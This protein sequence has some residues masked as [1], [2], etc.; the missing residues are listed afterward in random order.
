MGH[1]PIHS[2]EHTHLR[3]SHN[4]F[5]TRQIHLEI[6]GTPSSQQKSFQ[7]FCRSSAKVGPRQAGKSVQH[8]WN[9]CCFTTM[10]R[11]SWGR[12]SDLRIRCTCIDPLHK[13]W[14]SF[15]QFNM[16]IPFHALADVLCRMKRK[17]RLRR[18][19]KRK[20]KRRRK[21]RKR[22]RKRKLKL[23]LRCW[24]ILHEL[25]RLRWASLM[26]LFYTFIHADKWLLDFYN[27]HTGMDTCV[28][29][30]ISGYILKTEM[31]Y[32]VPYI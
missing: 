7:S 8:T 23:H 1:I 4:L 5:T 29:V 27:L 26:K 15:N 9:S 32:M 14:T 6:A 17:R 20:K 12:P 10:R 18:R 24:Q 22:R 3:F 21:R 13:A 2:W 25:W 11:A 16:L 28:L 31:C 19:R 30:H